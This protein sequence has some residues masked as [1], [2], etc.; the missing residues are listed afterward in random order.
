MARRRRGVPRGIAYWWKSPSIARWAAS[1]TSRGGGKFGIPCARLTPPWWITTRVISRMTDSVNPWTRFEITRGLRDHDVV[2]DRVH[3]HAGLLEP[4]DAARERGL[5]PVELQ[6]D[7]S[8]VG[9][10]VGAPDV[11]D[12]VEVL[13]QT[14]D[15]RLLDEMRGER[16]PHPPAGHRRHHSPA[17][18]DRRPHRD[19]VAVLEGRLLRLEEPDVLL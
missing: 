4:A 8:V 13:D 5:L 16:Q 19:L 3:L 14:V 11:D 7:P 10:H 18:G 2:L 6:R 1:S 9:L 17:S 15:D 12:D